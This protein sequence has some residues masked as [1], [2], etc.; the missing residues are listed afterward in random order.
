MSRIRPTVGVGLVLATALLTVLLAVFGGMSRMIR[1][2]ARAPPPSMEPAYIEALKAV[3]ERLPD[4]QIAFEPGTR[5]RQGQRKVVTARLTTQPDLD[6]LAGLSEDYVVQTIKTSGVM[7]LYLEGSEEEFLIDPI[8]SP[9]QALV[10]DFNEW[11]WWVTALKAGRK[12][13]VLRVVA[14]IHLPGEVMTT[15]LLVKEAIVVVD[16]EVRRPALAVVAG[17]SGRPR[18][19]CLGSQPASEGEV[20]AVGRLLEP[21]QAKCRR[22]PRPAEASRPLPALCRKS[23][24]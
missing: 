21:H 18:R 10:G 6:V 11:R 22:S 7:G 4:G 9:E 2:A 3:W 17:Q 20:E 15:D 16:Q 14:K 1:V 8:N 24:V 13:I 19:R 23:W 12:Q 5:M